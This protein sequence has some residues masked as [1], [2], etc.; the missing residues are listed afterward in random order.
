[1]SKPLYDDDIISIQSALHRHAS[2][3]VDENTRSE[4]QMGV[5]SGWPE[6]AKGTSFRQVLSTTRR[7]SSTPIRVLSLGRSYWCHN[8]LT[9]TGNGYVLRT[10]PFDRTYLLPPTP[11]TRRKMRKSHL[12]ACL[13]IFASLAS[14]QQLAFPNCT[15]GWDWVSR[16]TL[17][18]FPK[19]RPC[20]LFHSVD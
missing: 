20:P 14:A 5:S 15:T 9:G 13:P 4:D 19:F 2:N 7:Q 12:F 8:S 16:N 10:P 6:S 17:Q 3:L 18:R 1:M 11:M